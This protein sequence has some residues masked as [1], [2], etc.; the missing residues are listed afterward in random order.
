MIQ[1]SQKTD[2]IY[3][4]NNFRNSEL[5][6]KRFEKSAYVIIASRNFFHEYNL[7]SPLDG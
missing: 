2:Q 4:R 6:L 1:S 7:F 3:Y 5:F